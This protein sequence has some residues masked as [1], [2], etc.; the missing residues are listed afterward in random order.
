MFF[1]SKYVYVGDEQEEEVC[2]DELEAG[3]ARSNPVEMD[4]ASDSDNDSENSDDD[5]D[6]GVRV[7]VGGSVHRR[8]ASARHGRYGP[9]Q[10]Q[11]APPP[12]AVPAAPAFASAP[13]PPPQQQPQRRASRL[14][15]LLSSISSRATAAPSLEASGPPPPPPPAPL[16]AAAAPAAPKWGKKKRFR[17]KEKAATKSAASRVH[18]QAV[19]TNVI[20]VKLGTLADDV[21]LHTGDAEFCS[22]CSIVFNALSKVQDGVW[23][24]EFCGTPNKV[25]LAPEETPAD[26]SVDYILEPA[27]AV[28]AS[29]DDARVIF[30]MD[31]SGSMCVTTE[32]EGRIALRGDRTQQL[33]QELRAHTAGSR[34]YMPG[35]RRDVTYVSRLQS[36]QA[37]VDLQLQSMKK[38]HPS[39]SVGLVTFSN[40]VNVIG[41][42]SSE[43]LVLAGDRLND[44]DAIFKQVSEKSLVGKT[45]GESCSSLSETLFGLEEG[46]QTALGPALVAS[47]AL[48]A[49][50]PGSQVFVCTDGLAN[51]GVGS[52]DLGDK[53]DVATESQAAAFYR[54]VGQLAKDK[55]VTISVISIEGAECKLEHLG[56]AADMTGGD[57]ERVNP[58]TLSKE[59]GT[60]LRNPVIATQVSVSMTVHR[61]LFLRDDTAAAAAQNAAADVFTASRDLGSVNADSET[62]F[63]FGVRDKHLLRCGDGAAAA[64]E[65]ETDAHQAAALPF[66]VQIRFTRPNGMQCLRVLTQEKPITEQRD[67]AEQH[68]NV[69]LCSAHVAQKSARLAQGGDYERARLNAYAYRNMMGRACTS[70]TAQPQQQQ[71][72]D[73]FVHVM[74]ELDTHVLEA[75]CEEVSD[76]LVDLAAQDKESRSRERASRRRDSQSRSVFKMKKAATKSFF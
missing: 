47:V 55:G 34:Q 19:D 38:E 13:P 35:Q 56:V 40:E 59:F 10:A 65:S 18:R 75:Q 29:E 49:K 24:C 25:D 32:V 9:G 52:L 51:V 43:P 8:V 15:S 57:V 6:H 71:Q 31:T 4:E 28:A 2:E 46:G 33:T 68:V 45:V 23:R 58:L 22:E 1:A 72:F 42:C 14:S 54:E 30:C 67:Q 5:G 74:D 21:T 62:L 17:L 61:G 48:A 7:N 26:E 63:E 16:A 73:K 70:E 66:Q 69:A 37:A 36:V 64:T 3:W 60:M 76:G 20:S 39:R 41:D 53:A 27:P 11:Q 12:L 44:R 50:R